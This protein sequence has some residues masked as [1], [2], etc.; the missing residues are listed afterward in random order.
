MRSSISRL[1]LNRLSWRIGQ[2][3]HMLA[4]S[5][6]ATERAVVLKRLAT[7]VERQAMLLASRGEQTVGGWQS[8][9]AHLF[10]L[11]ATTDM[12]VAA[13]TPWIAPDDDPLLE[14]VG[15]AAVFLHLSAAETPLM[16]AELLVQLRDLLQTGLPIPRNII[17]R[18]AADLAAFHLRAAGLGFLEARTAAYR[19][20]Q[21]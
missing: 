21:P 18:D 20:W 6:T 4:V 2:L 15:V 16:R 7:D 13:A 10:Y 8:P 9:R 17:A 5:Q 19:G 11:V 14:V 1:Q 12:A 3:E